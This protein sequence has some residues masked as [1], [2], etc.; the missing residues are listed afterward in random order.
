MTQPINAADPAAAYIAA[1]EQVI[2][3]M[4]AGQVFINAE[5]LAAMRSGGWPEL[6]EPRRM[7]SMLLR[8]RSHGY[9][10]K[11]GNFATP[12]RSHGGVTSQWRRTS[13]AAD[14]LESS[15]GR[16]VPKPPSRAV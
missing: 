16:H 4:P 1:A 15:I 3:A 5:V 14:I 2:L 6:L 11:I 10:E 12:A 8:L 9:A 13:Q 7:G